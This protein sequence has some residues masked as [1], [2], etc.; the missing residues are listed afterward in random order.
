[1]RACWSLYGQQQN[2]NS[3]IRKQK[4][5][6]EAQLIC[7][8]KYRKFTGFVRVMKEKRSRKPSKWLI[9]HKQNSTKHT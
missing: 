6:K 3:V 4:K 1:V 8:D 5:S 7:I 2:Q 9:G